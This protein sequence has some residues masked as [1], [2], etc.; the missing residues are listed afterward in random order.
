MDE[1]APILGLLEADQGAKGLRRALAGL[2]GEG[3]QAD[4]EPMAEIEVDD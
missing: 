4:Q 3:L 2:L 1:P